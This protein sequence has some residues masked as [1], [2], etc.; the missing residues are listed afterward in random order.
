MQETRAVPE[1]PHARCRCVET[2][3]GIARF[4]LR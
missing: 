3:I 4:S 2:Y 1:K